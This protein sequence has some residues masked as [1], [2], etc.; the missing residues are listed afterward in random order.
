[1]SE[2]KEN[3][4]DMDWKPEQVQ[5]SLLITSP[6]L[7]RILLHDDKKRIL[8]LLIQ[9]DEMTIQELTNVTSINPGTIKRH[10]DD[11]IRNKL[12]FKSNQKRSE[13]NVKMK[14]Y[15]AVAKQFTI[16]IHIPEKEMGN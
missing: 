12:A 13:Y 4:I 14:Y 6:E 10:I 9:Q 16:D 2:K 3:L 7:A 5:D 11:L 8:T 1:M 15:S